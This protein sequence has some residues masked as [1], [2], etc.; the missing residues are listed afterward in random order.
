MS[1]YHTLP[2]PIELTGP[3]E[4]E[5]E[6]GHHLV[7]DPAD[8]NRMMRQRRFRCD[9]CRVRKPIAELTTVVMYPSGLRGQCAACEVAATRE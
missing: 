5:C 9:S 4:M 7:L 1:D 2:T 3:T 8:L 6:E